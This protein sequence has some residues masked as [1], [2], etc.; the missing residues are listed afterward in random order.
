VSEIIVPESYLTEMPTTLKIERSANACLPLR[1]QRVGQPLRGRPP[2]TVYNSGSLRVSLA[3]RLVHLHSV[4]TCMP[5]YQ[6]ALLALVAR[7]LCSESD[8][9]PSTG[10]ST[11]M[12]SRRSFRF[13]VRRSPTPSGPNS[14]RR[15]QETPTP[16]R[17]HHAARQIEFVDNE[18]E[19]RLPVV[20]NSLRLE[21]KEIR[22]E[23][24]HFGKK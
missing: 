19:I 14:P 11:P 20:K 9:S 22:H 6:T 18:N 21:R 7:L 17:I 12:R 5:T 15:R 13:C 10:S 8:L 24:N 2:S 4:V 23:S 1:V 3:P 16:T